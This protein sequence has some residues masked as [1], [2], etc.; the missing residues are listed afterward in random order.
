M[1]VIGSAEFVESPGHAHVVRVLLLLRILLVDCHHVLKVVP[2]GAEVGS[3]S[4]SSG[5]LLH[6][7]FLVL[8]NE[9][10]RR[11]MIKPSRN[12][13]L[14]ALRCVVRIALSIEVLR[15]DTA[16]ETCVAWDTLVADLMGGPIHPSA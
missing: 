16:D 8:R 2:L 1:I 13:P 3:L 12:L 15:V 5:V 11:L 14:K 10:F 9:A 7:D 4:N 6:K